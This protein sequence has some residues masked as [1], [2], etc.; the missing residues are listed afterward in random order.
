[1]GEYLPDYTVCPGETLKEVMC[2]LLS[3]KSGLSMDIIDGIITGE[4]EITE[5]VAARLE[6]GT[7]T[8]AHFWINLQK[9]YDE[10]KKRLEKIEGKKQIKRD[11]RD[12][13]ILSTI[14]FFIFYYV[15]NQTIF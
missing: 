11:I 8:P 7:G 10:D 13:I 9:K 15:L 3:N 6:E 5:T 2:G 4:I 12:V 1:M 14:I